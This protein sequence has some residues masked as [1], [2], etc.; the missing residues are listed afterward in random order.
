MKIIFYTIDLD[1]IEVGKTYNFPL[2]LYDQKNRVVLIYPQT[3][4][5]EESY[6]QW[7]ANS[8]KGAVIQI[9]CQYRETFLAET[10]QE[11]NSLR[12]LNLARY[13]MIDLFK[14]RQ[15]EYQEL[16]RPEFLLKQEITKSSVSRNF[17]GLRERVRAELLD[18]PLDHSEVMNFTLALVEKLFNRDI[19][20]VKSACLV[21]F[22][23]Q[24]MNI[25]D[26][27]IL[28]DLILSA[29]LKDLG[30]CMIPPK[31]F[32]QPDLLEQ[33]LIYKKHP[34]LSLF[35]ASK[36]KLDLSKQAKRYIMEHHELTNGEG[37]PRGKKGNYIDLCSQILNL[38]EQ[39]VLI[40]QGHL[41]S[42]ELELTHVLKAF[43]KRSEI[44]GLKLNL[45]DRVLDSL[46]HLL[47]T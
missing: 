32:S 18:Y 3:E 16:Q 9:H 23:A 7:K 1:W 22:M 25:T 43:Q 2:F 41:G 5:D 8:E 24:Q 33:D 28:I 19:L 42:K 6:Q 17:S 26:K 29:L 38:A 35:I 14:K 34:Y 27:D 12:Q 30:F 47:E 20:S 46:D 4:V 44:S 15:Q 31:L 45:N 37:F 10:G 11:E 39:A 13:K 36:L 21:Y 40:S